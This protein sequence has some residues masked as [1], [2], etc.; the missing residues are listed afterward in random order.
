MSCKVNLGL[1]DCNGQMVVSRRAASPLAGGGGR[2][3]AEYGNRPL[4]AREATT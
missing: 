1:A 2:G 4:G 3:R